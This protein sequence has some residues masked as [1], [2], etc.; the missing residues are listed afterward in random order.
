MAAVV[1][2]AGAAQRGAQGSFVR[3]LSLISLVLDH[4]LDIP[5]QQQATNFVLKV[6]EFVCCLLQQE[7][8]DEVFTKRVVIA[9]FHY[10]Y[11]H[12]PPN[13]TFAG[14]VSRVVGTFKAWLLISC[15]PFKMTRYQ[16]QEL[17]ENILQTAFQDIYPDHFIFTNIVNKYFGQ[18]FNTNC[19]ADLA[20][21]ILDSYFEIFTTYKHLDFNSAVIHSVLPFKRWLVDTIAVQGEDHRQALFEFLQRTIHESYN[22]MSC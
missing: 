20:T 22:L 5:L 4:I 21:R 14:D 19:P 1:V 7:E 9:S 13:E 12:M 17:T 8:T 15:Q 2:F 16:I 18:N 6:D 10:F 11:D 3:K